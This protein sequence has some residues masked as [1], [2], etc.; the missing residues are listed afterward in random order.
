MKTL[1]LLAIAV[2]VVAA[3]SALLAKD[4]VALA[5][6]P[7]SFAGEYRGTCRAEGPAGAPSEFPMELALAPVPGREAWSFSIVYG[8]GERRQVRAYELL[9]GESPGRFRIDERNGIVLDAAFVGDTLFSCFTV[10]GNLIQA[11]YRFLGDAVDF[12]IT[13]Y[14]PAGPTGGKDRAPEVGTFGLA[15]LQRARLGKVPK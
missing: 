12:E 1:A 3:L 15:A 7:A 9:P 11:R 5:A 13:S 8:E 2:G 6:F 4:G 10:E 14:R